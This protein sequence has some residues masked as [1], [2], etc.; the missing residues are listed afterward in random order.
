MKLQKLD[1]RVRMCCFIGYKY[2]GGGYRVWDP[3]GRVMVESRDVV[4]FEDGLPPPTLAEVKATELEPNTSDDEPLASPLTTSVPT[5]NTLP[6]LAPPVVQALPHNSMQPCEKDVALIPDY[7]ERSTQLGL[8][9]GG[10]NSFL[11]Q[12][13]FSAGLP[14]GIQLSS[15]PDPRS[16]HKAMAAPD[17]DGWKDAMDREMENLCTHDVYEMVPR[18]PGMHTLRPGW[19]LHQKFKNG[20]FEK[21]KAR[22]VTHGN[23]QLP[24][25]DYGES[26]SP[27]MRSESL[28][29]LLSLVA[30]RDLDIV[31]FDI[32]SAYLH[33][34]LKEELY[35][36]QPN[37][38][39]VSGGVDRVWRLK[40]GLY[41]LVQV[42]RTWNE[43]LNTHMVSV[44]LTASP[45]DPAIYV[46]SKWN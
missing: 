14:G 46:K 32:T 44:G 18:V 17:A 35:V 29:M 40:K 19:V 1:D 23:H 37:G 43:E 36:E 42:E 30:I 25:M 31:Q 34:T 28:R 45:K 39:K 13:V 15:L 20:I 8:T 21:N 12:V 41:G 9:Q 38:Y 6:P 22:L 10:G 24:G 7:P 33:G 16:V 2:G 26:F 27:V 4:F 3:K 5:Q 11:A